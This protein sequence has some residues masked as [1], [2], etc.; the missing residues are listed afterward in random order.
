MFE[1]SSNAVNSVRNEVEICQVDA[2]VVLVL[3]WVRW[4]C[5][6]IALKSMNVMLNDN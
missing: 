2:E 1:L 4:R 6:I 3:E 5:D